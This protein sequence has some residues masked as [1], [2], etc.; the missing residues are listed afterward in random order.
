MKVEVRVPF[1]YD[2]DLVSKNSGLVC[3]E[4][5]LTNQAEKEECDINTLVKRFGITGQIPQLEKL[6]LQEEFVGITSYHDALNAL[7]AA[8]G[9]FMELPADLRKRFDHDPGK[10]VAFCS[11]SKNKDELIELGLVPRPQ[12]AVPIDVKIVGDH[13]PAKPALA[14]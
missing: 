1:V 4:K 7:I 2:A 13:S 14:Q 10:F 6:P 3:P 11:D 9:A 5:T 8:E 12:V